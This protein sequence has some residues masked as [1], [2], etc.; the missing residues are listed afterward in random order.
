MMLQTLVIGAGGWGREVLAQMQVDPAC[1]N[2][3]SIKGFLDSRP[4]VLA[5][6]DCDTPIVGDPRD[7]APSPGEAFICAIG[8]PHARRNYSQPLRDRGGLFLPLYSG[9]FIGP[10]THLG[11]GIILCHR[12]QVS[13]DVWIGDFTNIH[14]M[15][16]IGH[17]VRIGDYAQIGA[18][19][20]I[21]GGA[22]IGNQALIHP[23]ATILPGIQVGNSATVGAGSVVVKD[24]PAGATVFGNPARVIFHSETI[25]K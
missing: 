25:E 24:V 21:G 1:G 12:A 23:Q 14:T 22:R 16:V 8:D 15:A 17:D 9:A 6:T 5:A 7:Y 2:E 11:E 19:V 20:F 18:L 3:W 4:D 13:P 10:R